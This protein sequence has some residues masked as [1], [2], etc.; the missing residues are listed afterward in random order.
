MKGMFDP[1]TKFKWIQFDPKEPLT[2]DEDK[3]FK[4]KIQTNYLRML[5]TLLT[6]FKVPTCSGQIR[7]LGRTIVNGEL[8]SVDP[9][10]GMY[11]DIEFA[12]LEEKVKASGLP[13]DQQRQV[14]ESYTLSNASLLMTSE[15]QSFEVIKKKFKECALN[16]LFV[17]SLT[18]T[19]VGDSRYN[20]SSHANILIIAKNRGVVYWIEPQTTVDA[21][22]ERKMVTAIK[23]LVTDI[24]MSDPTVI[25]PVEVCPQALTGDRNCM[26]WAYMIFFI[27]MLNPAERDHN[28]LINRYMGKYPTREALSGQI[29][30]LKFIMNEQVKMLAGKRRSTFKRKSKR[31][32][33]HR[34]PRTRKLA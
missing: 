34:N 5:N 18:V 14:K 33:K 13:E 16:N 3:I 19:P 26:F 29:N 12:K 17:V 20:L 31:S 6:V 32:N 25:T 28:V 7:M 2:A 21:V 24:G 11:K 30:G 27:L 23:T 4:Q 1:E 15:M 22:Y 9:I 8:Q 10:F